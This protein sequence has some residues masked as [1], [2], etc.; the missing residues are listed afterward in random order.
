MYSPTVQY[1][2]CAILMRFR[3]YQFVITTD[4]EKMFWQSK[5]GPRDQDFQRI[6]WRPE[7]DDALETYRLTIVT[8]GTTP[9]S[10]MATNCLISLAEGSKHSDP[11]ASEIIQC[12]FYMDDLMSGADTVDE[13]SRL[14]K[15]ISAI[16]AS[17][18]LLLRKWCSNS[19]ELL[20]T[21]REVHQRSPICFADRC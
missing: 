21:Q 8:Y 5:I 4:V 9:I 14:Q 6:L 15:R 19:S 16:L 3:K 17:A 13:C 2:L 12:N 1:D 18:K 10:F 11:E 7:P 20:K